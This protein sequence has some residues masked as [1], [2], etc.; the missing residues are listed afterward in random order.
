MTSHIEYLRNIHVLELQSID[1]L[2]QDQNHSSTFQNF[3]TVLYQFPSLVS[4]ELSEVD[5]KLTGLLMQSLPVSVRRLSVGTVPG[6]RTPREEFTFP[7]EVH[8]ATLQLHNCLSRVGDLFRNTTFP[9]LKKISIKGDSWE[10]RHLLTWTKEDAQSL[11]D[12]VRTGR[13]S[14]LEDLII[15][16]CCLKG[17]GPELVEILK[18]ESLCSAEFVGCR[19]KYR[20]WQDHSQEHPGW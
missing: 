13:M 9:H 15:R 4:M 17:C 11:L 1:G 12:A 5:P 6:G 7:P 3:T 20:R 14:K 2:D 18:A 10:D 8:L 16:D 19:T